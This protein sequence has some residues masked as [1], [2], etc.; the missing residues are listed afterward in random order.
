MVGLMNRSIDILEELAH[1]SGNIF[2]LNRRGYLFVTGDPARIPDFKRAAEEAAELGAGPARYHTGQPGEPAYVPA[3]A[4]GFEGQPTGADVILD[5]TLIRQH[6][7]YLTERAVAAVHA[8]RAFAL[9][10]GD[11]FDRQG[12][13]GERAGQNPRQGF[14]EVVANPV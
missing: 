14:D 12:F 6:F 7:P 11:P 4:H 9:I 5:P 8:R 13:G 1:E 2:H 10:L 3:P